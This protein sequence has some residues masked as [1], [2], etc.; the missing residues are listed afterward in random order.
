MRVALRKDD[1]VAGH[2][3]HRRL[4]AHLDVALTFGD[5]MEDHDALGAGLEER[6]RGVGASA[7]GST[8]AQ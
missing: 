6:R 2:Q 5:Q 1:R 7:T 4:V 3:V 8:R